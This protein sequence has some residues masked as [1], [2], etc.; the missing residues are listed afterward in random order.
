MCKFCEDH[1]DIFDSPLF[2]HI[3]NLGPDGDTQIWVYL[4]A[5]N[6]QLCMHLFNESSNKM[7]DISRGCRFCPICGKD[8][9]K[10]AE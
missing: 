2:H 10:L 9:F 3:T 8:L 4:D 1:D 7:T 5:E 6:M